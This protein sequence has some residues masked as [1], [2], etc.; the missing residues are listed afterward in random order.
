MHE[1]LI[2]LTFEQNFPNSSVATVIIVGTKGV[3]IKY[4]PSSKKAWI[5][6]P[7]SNIPEEGAD[8]QVEQNRAKRI[9]LSDTRTRLNRAVQERRLVAVEI[10]HGGIP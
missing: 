6:A 1:D 2:G 9:S 8:R 4:F 3:L 7:F 10:I 5:L